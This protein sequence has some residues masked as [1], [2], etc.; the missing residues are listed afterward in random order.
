V[1]AD[2]GGTTFDISIIDKGMPKTTTWG[3][4][5]EYPIKLPMVDMKTIGAG[6]GS[7]AWIDEGGVL[8]VGPQSAGSAPGPACYGW[9]G[10][11][12]TVT[13]ANLVVGRLN[14]AYFLGGR[15]PLHPEKAW[16]AIETHV[17]QPMAASVEEAALSIIRIV[18]ANMAKGIGGVSVQRG[19]DLREFILVPFGGA[20]AN[21]AVDISADLGIMTIVVPQMGGNFSAVGLAVAD[22]Q[23]DYVRTVARRQDDISPERI[24]GTFAIMETEGIRQLKAENVNDADI[25]VEWSADLRYEG[26]SWELNTPVRRNERFQAA[27]L[28]ELIDAFH[29]LHQQIYSYYEPAGHLEFINLRVR[30][31]GR[32]PRLT[33]HEEPERPTPLTEALKERRPVYFT[34]TG[35]REIP[36]YERDP[37]GCGSVVTGPC[38][39]EERISTTLIPDGWAGKIDR[40]R[41]IVITPSV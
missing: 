40:F 5:T 16:E 11:L 7:I 32:N 19:Y 37:L 9:G 20:A 23:H 17:A 21:H 38:L 28:Q 31:A 24:A 15:I 14:P 39:V 22:I 29:T 2:M 3:G 8:N 41:N 33:V 1:G 6:G 34:G 4:V 25:V 30:V 13:D 12:P 35:F 36:V 27:E 10:S 26:Q 18:N